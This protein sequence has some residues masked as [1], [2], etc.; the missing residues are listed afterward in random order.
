MW[1]EMTKPLLNNSMP[2]VW[3]PFIKVILKLG[4]CFSPKPSLSLTTSWVNPATWETFVSVSQSRTLMI[5]LNLSVILVLLTENLKPQLRLDPP[6]GWIPLLESLFLVPGSPM[7]GW[8]RKSHKAG[9]RAAHD[10]H[11]ILC[12]RQP[13]SRSS[14]G[15]DMWMLPRAT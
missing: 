7:M 12:H 2:N 5:P 13:S 9:L 8:I 11:E 14:L 3:A 15:S 1:I 4:L 10:W 6:K